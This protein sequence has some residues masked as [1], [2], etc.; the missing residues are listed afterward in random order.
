MKRYLIIL[1][2][3]CLVVSG[4]S[5]SLPTKTEV[6]KTMKKVNDYWISTNTD[7]GDNKWARAAYFTGNMSFYHVYPLQE[8]LDYAVLWANNHQWGL[9]RGTTTRIADDQC[10]GQTYID[11]YLLGASTDT[12]KLNDITLSIQNMV[13]STKS[14]DWDWI[15]AFYMA[16]PV[17]TRLGV[18]YDDSSYF[19][20]MFALYSDTKYSRS[21]FNITDGLWY[22]DQNYDPPYLT[23]NGLNCYWS[24]G[25]GWVMGGLA[26]TLQYLPLTDAHRDDYVTT[27]KLMATALKNTQRTDGFWNVSLIDPNDYGGPE[28][29]GTGF[30]TYSI[31]WGVNNGLLDSAEYVPV[32]LKAWNGLV[33][34]AVHSDGKVG[35]IQG[36]GKEPSSAQP[37]DYDSNS[38][39]GVGAFL[40]AGS[41]IVK[42]ASGE[43]PVLTGVQGDIVADTKI[44]VYPNPVRNTLKINSRFNMDTD[45]KTEVYT[46]Q[47]KKIYESPFGETFPLQIDVSSY[48]PGIYLVKMISGGKCFV[49]KIVKE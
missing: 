27:F 44:S 20:K 33:S 10:I 5:Q 35:Y 36:P 4:K 19:D 38:D 37:V 47:G 23:P 46:L 24:R 2:F 3:S 7:P 16:M 13:N 28:T 9:N 15:D 39:F 29:S 1:A 6:I 25:N 30:F 45:L 21:L 12:Y 18:L 41:E 8:Y 49:K 48:I 14:N 26:R 34:I 40:L 11:L 31:A 32:V 43:L 22:R 17:F 42:L